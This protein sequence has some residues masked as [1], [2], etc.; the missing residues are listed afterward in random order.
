MRQCGL[1]IVRL[2][3]K[4]QNHSASEGDKEKVIK[5]ELDLENRI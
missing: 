5:L 2:A 1:S 3:N 4:N